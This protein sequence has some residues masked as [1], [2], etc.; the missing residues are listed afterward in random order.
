[1]LFR[2]I[3]FSYA[4]AVAC[5]LHWLY[6]HTTRPPAEDPQDSAGQLGSPAR[7]PSL[8]TPVG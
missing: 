6:G 7:L 1:M 8:T 5:T 3:A 4:D 2:S